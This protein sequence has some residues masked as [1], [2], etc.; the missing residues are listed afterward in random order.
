MTT[1]DVRRARPFRSTLKVCLLA[2]WVA[3][4]AKAGEAAPADLAQRLLSEA[5]VSGGL[6][7]HVGCGDA[8]LTSAFC[9]HGQCLVHGLD[10]D[11]EQLARAQSHLVE[12][13]LQGRVTVDWWDG[14]TLP[15]VDD[16]VNVLV[17]ENAEQLPEPEIM[18]V[19]VPNGTAY[20]RS[21]EDW[22]KKVKPWPG[23]IDEWSHWLH[24]PDNNAV[25]KDTRVGISRSLQWYMPPRWSRQ[26]NLP[27]GFNAMVSGGGKIYYLVDGAPNAVYGPGKWA[28]VARD[29]FNGLELWRRDMT[30]WNMKAWGAEERYG[31]RVGR[32]HGAP[33][34]QA[35]RR[36]VAAGDRLFITLGFQA[37]V[38]LLD[39]AT[40]DVLKEFPDTRGAGEIIYRDGIL[41]VARNTYQPAPAKEILAVDVEAGKTLWTNGDYKGIAASTGYQ[42]KH[43]NAYLTLGTERLFLVDENDVVALDLTTGREAWKRPMALTDEIVGDIDYR[44]SNF[45]TLVYHEGTVFFCQIH[46]GTQNMNRWEMKKLHIDAID[47]ATGE[48]NWDY[49]GGTLAHVTPADLFVNGR[50]VWTLDPALKA[51]GNCDARLLG[52]DCRTGRVATEHHLEKIT[53]SHHHRCYRNKAT[54]KYYLMGE[55]GIEYI[56]FQSGQSDVHYWLRGACRYGVMPANGFVYVPPHNCACYLGTLVHGLVALKAGPSFTAGRKLSDRLHQGPAYDVPIDPGSAAGEADWPMFRHDPARSCSAPVEL[57][58][59]LAPRWTCP[60]GATPTAPVVVKDN[61]FVASPDTAQVV[62]VDALSGRL[63]WRFATDG[64]VNAPPTYARGRLV[65]GTRAGTLYVLTA[66][67]GKLAWSFK[68]GPARVLLSA[69]GRLESPWPLNGSPIVLDGKIYCVAGRSMSLDSGL[70]VYRLD[71]RT[72]ALLEESHLRTDPEPKGEVENNLLADML[73]SDGESVYMKSIRFDRNDVSK[74]TFEGSSQRRGSTVTPKEILRCQTEMVDDSWLNCCFWAYRGCQAQQLVFDATAAYG[75]SGPANV[76][77]GGSFSHDV[78][79][80]GSGYRLARWTLDKNPAANPARPRQEKANVQAW[81]N[82]R[83][84][85]RARSMVLTRDRLYLAGT[86]DENPLRDFWAAYENRRGAVLLAVSRENGAVAGRYRLDSEPVYNGIAA[87]GEHLF[88][89]LRNGSIV[90]WGKAGPRPQRPVADRDTARAH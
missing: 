57:P 66:E 39:G 88:L 32:F 19:L 38:S 81:K 37:P 60:L 23:D 49:T 76:R 24:G 73:V 20:I 17:V 1:H 68:A 45:C 50:R 42:R 82:V 59:S 79:R 3:A 29:A 22:E 46:P 30:Q 55:E 51:D 85:V 71:L 41:Y 52:L 56:D 9:S 75:V 5:N 64:P 54:A 34:Y 43:T 36:I 80:P 33:D 67:D 53:H 63:K 8:L 58:E 6:V 35:P 48:L 74:Y 47:A 90:C 70:Y 44:Y 25:S 72:G 15:Y 62:C 26:H 10:T 77:W 86:P 84:D 69:F 27:A 40:G 2:C 4:G 87:A 31:G 89:S 13:G 83:V 16:L 18:R 65:F 21:G 12:N 78:Y 7:V 28:L 11:R 61:V 14:R